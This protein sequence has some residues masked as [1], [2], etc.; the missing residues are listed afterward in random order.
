MSVL[1][2]VL[3][4]GSGLLTVPVLVFFVEIAA[5]VSIRQRQELASNFPRPRVR[6]VGS[7]P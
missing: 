5:S 6:S 2:F 7:C 1:F 3:V 4:L